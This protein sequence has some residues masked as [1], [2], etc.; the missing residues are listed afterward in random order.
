[1]CKY[2]YITS[3]SS[4]FYTN[5]YKPRINDFLFHYLLIN[6]LI[7]LYDKNKWKY[8]LLFCVD[9]KKPWKCKLFYR[10]KKKSIGVLK[11]C[12]RP[13][14]MQYIKVPNWV[15]EAVGFYHCSCKEIVIFLLSGV[16][17]SKRL[18]AILKQL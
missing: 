9:H 14:S 2:C 6:I 4:S 13:R 3:I 16:C 7:F 10:G 12:Q 8:L 17:V 1:M 5:W 18:T 15:P 11:F